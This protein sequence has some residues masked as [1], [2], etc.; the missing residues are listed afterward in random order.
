[1]EYILGAELLYELAEHETI[2][3]QQKLDPT[4][5]SGANIICVCSEHS[6]EFYTTYK[7]KE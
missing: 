3:L 2:Q 5:A 4:L 6:P 1:M 7:V